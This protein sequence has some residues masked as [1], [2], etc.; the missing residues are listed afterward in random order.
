MLGQKKQQHDLPQ[1]GDGDGLHQVPSFLS[2]F[3]ETSM[4][5]AVRSVTGLR[6][7]A[8]AANKHGPRDPKN[9][10]VLH[11]AVVFCHMLLRW[12]GVD[13][14]LGCACWCLALILVAALYDR[15]IGSVGSLV[16]HAALLLL[17]CCCRC[18]WSVCELHC[19]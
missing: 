3:P 10:K 1:A 19:S 16:H 7:W 6:R 8:A 14:I 15:F 4:L 5:G 9:D 2:Q 18:C 11:S 12:N 13:E 17:C